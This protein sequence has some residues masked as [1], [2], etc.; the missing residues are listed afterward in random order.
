VWNARTL[1]PA[2]EL[3]GCGTTPERWRSHPT[4]ACSPRPRPI[5]RTS[6][7]GLPLRPLRVWDVRRRRLTEFREGLLQRRVSSEVSPPSQA[8]SQP[9][10]APQ[11]N[12]TA[13]GGPGLP[14]PTV[15]APGRA[16]LCPK[17]HEP[18]PS[19]GP[20]DSE[21]EQTIEDACQTA[22]AILLLLRRDDISLDDRGAAW[23]ATVAIR[24]GWR[25]ASTARELPM[26][27]MR[28]GEPEDGELPEPPASAPDAAE[29][30]IARV[31]HA[32]RVA[33]LRTLKESE[34]RAL[35]L[36]ALGYSYNEICDLT[37]ASYTAVNRRLSEGRA[38]LRALECDAE[39][40]DAD[41]R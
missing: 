18:K 7:T 12:S 30:A 36:K 20:V 17:R 13:L 22:W 16:P 9:S 19:T 8:G 5:F 14:A 26:G 39:Q 29:Q 34:R 6:T 10:A 38:R 28:P 37:A 1:A 2:G 35:Y 4:A 11:P 23:L 15:D 27:A 3:E 25:L 31:E 24:E 40:G 41:E 32:E 21:H 33:D